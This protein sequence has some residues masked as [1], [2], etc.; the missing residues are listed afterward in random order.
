MLTDYDFVSKLGEAPAGPGTILYCSP[1][2]QEKRPASPS[3]DIYALAATFF[4]VIFEREPFRYGGELEKKR[5]LN[6]EGLDANEYPILREFFL[7]KA[8]RSDPGSRF[9]NVSEALAALRMQQT[10]PSAAAPEQNTKPPC[11]PQQRVD[12]S[13]RRAGTARA[14]NRVAA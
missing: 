8:T 9:A 14:T 11:A 12:S 2:Y 7:H 3:D 13:Q 5:G 10:Q 1:S 4:H 6:W